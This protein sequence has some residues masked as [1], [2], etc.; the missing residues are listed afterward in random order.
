MAFDS[1]KHSDTHTYICTKYI[2][3]SPDKHI[4]TW[5][6]REETPTWIF[7]SLE[8]LTFQC[9][10]CCIYFAYR[11]VEIR[12]SNETKI[13]HS[14]QWILNSEFHLFINQF[15]DLLTSTDTCRTAIFASAFL[16]SR[17]LESILGWL[18][19]RI[20]NIFQTLLLDYIFRNYNKIIKYMKENLLY[21]F[22]N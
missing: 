13:N 5:H 6:M 15:K 4:I 1:F 20:N 8:M 22:C 18:N 17:C 19:R 16:W 11:G 12:F 21:I 14:K 3:T 9:L 2:I 7:R 10:T